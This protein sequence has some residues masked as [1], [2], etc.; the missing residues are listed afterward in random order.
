MTAK[1]LF[2]AQIAVPASLLAISSCTFCSI[3]I[4]ACKSATATFNTKRKKERKTAA[5]PIQ[6][7][8]SLSLSLSQI[9]KKHR[10]LILLIAASKQATPEA[11]H[12]WFLTFKIVK[13]LGE[14]LHETDRQRTMSEERQWGRLWFIR[15]YLISYNLNELKLIDMP[16]SS[17]IRW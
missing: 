15:A 8:L 1:K 17:A 14:E 9:R 5:A 6:L 12:S 11:P 13:N 4:A 2:R 3:R 10:I 7:S 16:S